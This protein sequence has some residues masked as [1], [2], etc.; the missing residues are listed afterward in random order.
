MMNAYCHADAAEQAQWFGDDISFKSSFDMLDMNTAQMISS[1]LRRV[2]S[3]GSPTQRARRLAAFPVAGLRQ[4]SAFLTTHSTLGAQFAASI[5]LNDAVCVAIRQA[6]EQWNGTGHPDHLR[7]EELCVAARLVQVAAPVEVFSRRPGVDA[8]RAMVRRHRGTRFDPAIADLFCRHAPELLDGLD[9][10]SGWDAVIDAEPG[11][12]R[13]VAGS[14][15]D[16]VLEAMADLVDMK[17][18][19]LAGHSRGV[20]NLA[21]EAARIAGL[22]AP[23]LTTLR[24]DP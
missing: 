8:A 3:H 6:Y 4:M 24:A 10:A 16:D 2:G 19:Y 17:S 11:L 20:A 12:A 22:P 14:D 21:G 7:G 23:D 5:G 15:L 1:I 18:P 9:E 13:R